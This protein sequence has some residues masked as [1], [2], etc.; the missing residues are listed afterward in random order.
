M[1]WLD[2]LERKMG[3]CYIP[4]LMKYL[5]IAMAGIF[6]LD[7]LPLPRSA[8]QLLYF[9][10]GLILEGQ[11]WRVFTFMAL[12]PL[13]ASLLGVV[14]RLYFYYFLGT[15]L[16]SRWGSRKFNLYILIG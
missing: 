6:I 8:T 5:V 10:K 7:Y 12:P 4:G 15:A 13:S 16:E 9:D 2:R 14:L 1:N 11:I 3:K